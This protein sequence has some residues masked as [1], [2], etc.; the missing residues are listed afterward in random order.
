[1]GDKK[2]VTLVRQPTVYGSSETTV[3]P[4]VLVR[5]GS[6]VVTSKTETKRGYTAGPQ[7]WTTPQ[8]VPYKM[9]GDYKFNLDM[10]PKGRLQ[11]KASVQSTMSLP[12]NQ[13]PS[14]DLVQMNAARTGRATARKHDVGSDTLRQHLAAASERVRQARFGAPLVA[15]V[16]E[17]QLEPSP[18]VARAQSLPQPVAVESE[19]TTDGDVENHKPS[20]I[21]KLDLSELSGGGVAGGLTH[22]EAVL[23]QVADSITQLPEPVQPP[24]RVARL[25]TL[26]E[27]TKRKGT[28]Y[29]LMATNRNT[30]FDSARQYEQ[31][32]TSIDRTLDALTAR[33]DRQLTER[34]Q[35]RADT[36]RLKFS[37]FHIRPHGPGF[38]LDMAAMR[39]RAAQQSLEQKISWMQ[40]KGFYSELIKK[41]VESGRDISPAERY[42]ISNIKKLVES[43]RIVSKALLFQILRNCHATDFSDIEFYRMVEFLRTA[44]NISRHEFKQF[45][46][47]NGFPGQAPVAITPSLLAED[48]KTAS[49]FRTMTSPGVLKAPALTDA[50]SALAAALRSDSLQV[51]MQK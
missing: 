7:S 24:T 25:P 35:T 42:V 11:R 6:Y 27:V 22:G 19:T 51:P 49:K 28:V 41:F 1:M 43:G 45:M 48:G 33:L 32:R 18:H 39:V 29:R 3:R 36:F 16:P 50:A 37:N 44:V 23:L 5:T 9:L 34:S 8:N 30:V 2:L 13:S 10:R 17:V 26:R 38:A 12:Y 4:T 14:P 31:T 21:P 20:V 47:D 40:E 46:F 15:L